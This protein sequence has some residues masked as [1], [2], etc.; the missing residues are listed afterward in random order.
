MLNGNRRLSKRY[1]RFPD[2]LECSTECWGEVGLIEAERVAS[3]SQEEKS[4]AKINLPRKSIEGKC[5]ISYIATDDFG[6]ELV[7]SDR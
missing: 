4:N 7:R 2:S 3:S 5:Q 6:G 1:S